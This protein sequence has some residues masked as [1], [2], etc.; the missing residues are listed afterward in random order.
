MEVAGNRHWL[1]FTMDQSTVL[2]KTPKPLSCLGKTSSTIICNG[3]SH[4]D[5][6]IV[7]KQATSMLVN[8]LAGHSGDSFFGKEWLCKITKPVTGVKCWRRSLRGHDYQLTQELN[9]GNQ[10]LLTS[11]LS[12]E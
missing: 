8:P 5:G 7:T 9:P 12:L 6:Q 4:L 1:T 11:F 2:L 10:R 3:I